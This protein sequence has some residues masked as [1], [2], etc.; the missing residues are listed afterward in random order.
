MKTKLLLL[1]CLLVPSLGFGETLKLHF[2][3]SDNEQLAKV[4]NVKAPFVLIEMVSSKLT[5][6]QSQPIAISLSEKK[7]IDVFGEDTKKFYS[8]VGNAGVRV[9]TPYFVS[10]IRKAGLTKMPMMAFVSYL[11]SSIIQQGWSLTFKKESKNALWQTYTLYF[12]K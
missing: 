4:H 1:L 9:I 3:V 2:S 5:F 11:E 7:W 10:T 6:E 8:Q 12:K